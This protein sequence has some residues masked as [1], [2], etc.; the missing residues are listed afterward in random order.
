MGRFSGWGNFL[1]NFKQKVKNNYFP[2]MNGGRGLYFTGVII[3]G[4]NL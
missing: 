4:E 2:G 1:K 3:V